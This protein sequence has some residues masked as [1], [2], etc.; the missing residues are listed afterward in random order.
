MQ[1]HTQCLSCMLKSGYSAL[2][3]FCMHLLCFSINGFCC[4]CGN[5][6][7]VNAVQCA[8][9]AGWWFYEREVGEKTGHL[10]RNDLKTG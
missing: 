1:Q 9:R 7:L 5:Q 4:K 8:G 3:D 10:G 6:A 2:K